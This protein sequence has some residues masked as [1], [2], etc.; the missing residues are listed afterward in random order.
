[1]DSKQIT[2]KYKK[3]GWFIAKQGD[4]VFVPVNHDELDNLIGRLMQ[5]CDLTGDV[6]QRKALKDTIKQTTRRW[7]DNAFMDRGYTMY[8]GLQ[9]KDFAGQPTKVVNVE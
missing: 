8:V 6:E 2:P 7:L 1:M 4:A 3:P 9:E 5:I